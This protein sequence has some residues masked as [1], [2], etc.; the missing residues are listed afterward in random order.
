MP[1]SS[2]LS[3]GEKLLMYINMLVWTVIWLQTH[4]KLCYRTMPIKWI[5][6]NILTDAQSVHPNSSAQYTLNKDSKLA[7]AYTSSW[8]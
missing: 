3:R 8:L 1:F 7:Q 5:Q 2:L 6:I 4:Q